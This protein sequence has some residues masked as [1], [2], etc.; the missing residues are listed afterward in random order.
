MSWCAAFAANGQ[1]YEITRMITD[2]E[3]PYI[4]ALAPTGGIFNRAAV[5]FIN[6]DTGEIEDSVDL[7]YPGGTDM[8]IHYDAE[9]LM[10]AQ[11][12][13]WI[14]RVRLGPNP[15]SAGAQRVDDVFRVDAGERRT[16]YETSPSFS[17]ARAFIA[18]T[19]ARTVIR[20]LTQVEERG[21]AAVDPTGRFYYHSDEN[22]PDAKVIKLNV[23]SDRSTLVAESAVR[24]PGGENLVLSADGSRLFWHGVVYDEDLNELRELGEEIYATSLRGSLAF[25][26]QNVYDTRT[27]EV[28]YTLPVETTVMAVSNDQ[29]TLYYFDP[30][31]GSVETIPI[32][33][34]AE[35]PPAGLDPRPAPDSGV[36]PSLS[37]LR[38]ERSPLATRYRVYFGTDPDALPWVANTED[39][40]WSLPAPLDPGRTYY[41]RI[42]IDSISGHLTGDIWSFDTSWVS[43]A[44]DALVLTS[45]TTIAPPP[46]Q[47]AV[48]SLDPQIGWNFVGAPEWVDVTPVA[49]A[50]PGAV[51]ITFDTV[52]LPAGA[53]RDFVRFAAGGVEF[54]LPIELELFDLELVKMVADPERPYV[55]ALHRGSG[56]GAPGRLLFLRTDTGD[57]EKTLDVGTNPTDLAVHTGEGR[58]Y[59]TNQGTPLTR[60]VDLAT[61][62]ELEPFSLG[63][64]VASVSAGRPGRLYFEGD[65]SSVTDIRSVDTTNGELGPLIQRHV[66]VGDAA[67]GPTGD[68]YY[69]ADGSGSSAE[70]TK[71]DVRTDRAMEVASA[72]QPVGSSNL[73]ISAD[74]TRLFWQGAIYDADLNELDFLGEE[75]YA[76]SP[77]GNLAVTEEQVLDLRSGEP[78]FDLP[79]PTTVSAFGGDLANLYVFDPVAHAIDAIP[80][81]SI[82]SVPGPGFNPHPAGAGLEVLPLPQLRWA[83]R[84]AAVAYRVYFG[85]DPG[86]LSLVGETSETAIDLPPPLVPG[87]TYYWQ[88]EEVRYSGVVA[89]PV[90]SFATAPVRVEPDALRTTAIPGLPAVVRRVALSAPDPQIGWS[91]SENLSWLSVA[92][93]SGGV[94]E[95][96]EL[97]FDPNGLALGEYAGTLDFS[98]GGVSF[99]I[100]VSLS[101]VELEITQL[102]ADPDRPV[103]YG[104]QRGSE[105]P[106]SALLLLLDPTT[107]EASEVLAI[108]SN[109]TDMTL[110]REEGRLYVSNFGSDATQVVDLELREVLAPLRLGP[111]V[112]RLNAG[113]PGR[114]YFHDDGPSSTVQP[115]IAD[116]QTGSVVGSVGFFPR[117]DAEVDPSGSDYYH[118]EFT[119]SRADLIRYDIRTDIPRIAGALRRD[120]A[121]GALVLTRDGSRLYWGSRAY[122]RDLEE[123]VEFGEPI[124]SASGRGELAVADVRVFNGRS[125]APLFD[126]PVR[127]QIHAVHDARAT[128]LY[129]D[130]QRKTIESIPVDAIAPAPVPSSTPSPPDGSSQA[131]PLTRLSWAPLPT[132]FSYRVFFGTAPDALTLLG[133]VEGDS[134]A[135]PD[136]L[137]PGQVYYW[138]VDAVGFT[139]TTP[140]P[141]W[142][143]RAA[144]LVV[145]PNTVGVRLLTNLPPQM[146]TLSLSSPDLQLGWSVSENIDWL[147]VDRSSGAVP[148]ELVLTIDVE[149]L[150]AGSYAGELVFS[151][152]GS[153]FVVPVELD[154][155]QMNLTQMAT[156]YQRPFVYALHRGTGETDDAFLLILD[157][158]TAEVETLIPVGTNATDMTVHEAEGRLYVANHGQLETRVV[159]LENRTLLAPLP[160]GTDVYTVNAGRAGRLYTEGRRHGTTPIRV[161][162]TSTGIE[163]DRT[164][165]VRIGDAETDATGRYYFHS[166]D[167][168][169]SSAQIRKYD[170]QLDEPNLVAT[171]P[172]RTPGS[173][174]LRVSRSGDRIF[175]VG[176]VYDGELVEIGVLGSEVYATTRAGRLAFSEDQLYDVVRETALLPLPFSSAVWA[177]SRDGE[178]AL[179]FDPATS[180]PRVYVL[181]DARLDSDGDALPIQLDNCPYIANADQADLDGD[182][183]GDVCD[184]CPGD[185]E[186]DLE[187][188]GVCGDVDVCPLA[189]DPD[190]RDTDQDGA[191][192]ACDADDDGDA[193]PDADD[194]CPQVA[195]SDQADDD[196]DGF[197]NAC[198]N[199]IDAPNGTLT[200]EGLVSRLQS[201]HPAITALVPDRFDF[202]EGET[203]SGISDGGNDMYDWGNRLSTNSWSSLAYQNGS[204]AERGFGPDGRYTTLKFPGLFALMAEQVSI[205]SF[206]ISGGLG[207]DGV[208]E[209]EAKALPLSDG[210]TLYLKRV[211]G[212]PN[213]SVN[214]LILIP[215]PS[216]RVEQLA[217]V[218]TNLDY[219]ELRGLGAIDRLFYLL[220]SREAGGFLEDADAIAIAEA[221][222]DNLAQSDGDGDGVGNVCDA[223]PDVNN[224]DQ[225]LQDDD[226]DGLLNPC[227][228]CPLDAENDIDGDGLCADVDNCPLVANPDQADLVHPNGVGDVCDDPDGDGV[229]DS[230]DNCVSTA[231]ADQA[232]RIHPNG[233]GDTCDDPDLDGIFDAADN[234]ADLVNPGQANGDS[235]NR[236]DLCDS[237]PS[238]A[239]PGQDE[240]AACFEVSTAPTGACVDLRIDLVSGTQPGVIELLPRQFERPERL[241]FEVLSDTFRTFSDTVTAYLNGQ[242]LFS[243]TVRPQS[244]SGCTN[245][246]EIFV[247]DDPALLAAW[248]PEGPNRVR[249]TG[250]GIWTWYAWVRVRAETSFGESEACL[251]DAGG[252]RCEDVGICNAGQSL[253]DFDEE[254]ELDA[255]FQNTLV[256]EAE[257]RPEAPQLQVPLDG[258]APGPVD[259]CVRTELPEA[260]YALDE[261]GEVFA[262]DPEAGLVSPVGTLPFAASA[263]TFDPKTRRLMA[264]GPDGAPW[265]QAFRVEDAGVGPNLVEPATAFRT[266][267]R[268]AGDAV[269]VQGLPPNVSGAFETAVAVD[270]VTG[271]TT[272]AASIARIFEE[273]AYEDDTGIVFGIDAEQQLHRQ[274]PPFRTSN[275]LIVG[276]L[277]PGIETLGVDAAGSLYGGGRGPESGRFYRIDRETGAATLVFTWDEGDIIDL[278]PIPAGTYRD[279]TTFAKD[280]E[281]GL[282]INGASCQAPVAQAIVPNEVECTEPG[283]ATVRLEAA[284]TRPG[285]TVAWYADVGGANERWLGEGAVVDA[286]LE[287]GAHVVT[288]QVTDAS[289]AM[290]S[291]TVPVEVHDT[292]PPDLSVVLSP[293]ALWPADGSLV[294]IAAAVQANDRCG[295][296]SVALLAVMSNEP[297]SMDAGDPSGD[298]Q[299][300]TPGTL[301]LDFAV[302]SEVARP[303]TGRRYEVRYRAVD[304][305]GNARENTRFLNVT[306]AVADDQDGDGIADAIERDVYGTD[307]LDADS[308]DDRIPD[309]V[310]IARGSDPLQ[311]FSAVAVPGLSLAA[312][313]LLALALLGWGWRRS[314][315][316]R[317]LSAP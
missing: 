203:G 211:W 195:N 60:V 75:I 224:P 53:Y 43:M 163:V 244:N 55:Y 208:G 313:A 300:V 19:D 138:R 191:G 303:A 22:V 229:V 9:W 235:D 280:Q 232:D 283:G 111:G 192:D 296:S 130:A 68:F 233:V 306:P 54:G 69:H 158:T 70:L 105:A 166:D 240:P 47:V 80:V 175:W 91:V 143:L 298:V 23:E 29:S 312:R 44:P 272:P 30:T 150:S 294:P 84:P 25:G 180:R 141:V 250:V 131:L 94:P 286:P 100:P 258:L 304:A 113:R 52:G 212:A 4:Y 189:F 65:R 176:S 157:D 269:V 307:P 142:S 183:I 108:G 63:T 302:R 315:A 220:V 291:D 207:A 87:Q 217:S 254:V 252:E 83:T 310:E 177:V 95:T 160:L 225:R 8:A 137:E 15:G 110:Q 199:C 67:T 59:I 214:H 259:L 38:W 2:H 274:V 123:Q 76:A 79:V 267:G 261:D 18:R 146:R 287:M 133:E 128:L 249:M 253:D 20:Q 264:Q 171:S 169:F 114:L 223:C 181:D 226:G 299:G 50:V 245:I 161:F 129:F 73:V 242:M 219:H 7:S 311:P 228:A 16:Y 288:L 277:L 230:F 62:A 202:T 234:C 152:D 282:A 221:F 251:Y 278:V 13:G 11:P 271:A 120:G 10:I 41:W 98:S 246:P 159:D 218:D 27:G 209:A 66:R 112:F 309:D 145:T 147:E 262:V 270:L 151:A 144:P 170:I 243:T 276:P 49:G 64:D 293:G 136:P 3:R 268:F 167:S 109:A 179:G 51:T 14:S 97:V 118:A 290:A 178:R 149:G 165:S 132:A 148:S 121:F 42:D 89:S 32:A 289:G 35:V 26:A 194:N 134:I 12:S 256:A 265:L 284:D 74:G 275:V 61:Q 227:D 188:D 135:L 231:N 239:N 40:E 103:V 36:L 154:L 117:G 205:D 186:N 78:V 172:I 115:S 139:E 216:G 116:T 107:G 153:D 31:T 162:D 77:R 6:T 24:G 58:L 255:L 86:A 92:P 119:L 122:D 187:S 292:E 308:D 204:I 196:A 237:C 102:L 126:L 248:N 297:E 88:I 17:F 106:E 301:D 185:A 127:T 164:S 266:I 168:L 210:F 238:V 193:L 260:F 71:Y 182:G 184:A 174:N 317:L 197:G 241:V 33:D 72:R 285:D 273:W 81:A 190:Q 314:R 279:C 1:P 34:I 201:T 48:T 257:I 124:Y 236:G 198:D 90:W 99:S 316:S 37:A 155:R 28:A 200:L 222:L 5:L 295:P 263:L 82:A 57:V 104:L 125:G 46:Q 281:I 45:P 21:D 101:V 173:S 39:T 96:L 85:S 206:Q 305:A 247:V 140:G 56:H 215:T 156:D 213:P 93:S